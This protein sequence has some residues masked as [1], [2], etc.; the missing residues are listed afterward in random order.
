MVVGSGGLRSSQP[1]GVA[2]STVVDGLADGAGEADGASML[3]SGV[4][5]DEAAALCVAVEADEAAAPG[6]GFNAGEAAGKGSGALGGA[7][8]EPAIAAPA[9]TSAAAA[10]SV[11]RRVA[12]SA[13]ER[14][15]SCP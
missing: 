14:L 12:P 6:V 3:G 9:A 1:A 10:I 7:S 2:L 11:L 8:F 13:F 15:S 5:A 4:G